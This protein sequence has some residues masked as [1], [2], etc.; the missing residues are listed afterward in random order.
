MIFYAVNENLSPAEIS[1]LNSKLSPLGHSLHIWPQGSA[2][3]PASL[4]GGIIVV[5][6]T[7]TTLEEQRAIAVLG[8]N[9][10]LVCIYTQPVPQ[11]SALVQ[12]FCSVEVDMGDG[13]LGA[14]LGGGTEVHKDYE[15][16][17]MKKNPQ[18]PHRC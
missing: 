5:R 7:S 12:N 3:V 9:K 6:P 17:P 11:V 4:D 14:V 15:G 1:A 2:L 10:K 18:K 8:Q 16:K 13:E